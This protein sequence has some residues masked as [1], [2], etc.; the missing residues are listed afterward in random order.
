MS[1]S[2]R[3]FAV[4]LAT[5]VGL[6]LVLAATGHPRALAQPAASAAPSP[7][8]T[9]FDLEIRVPDL[10]AYVTNGGPKALASSGP[11]HNA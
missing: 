10:E 3:R 7:S 8:A 6:G 11:G 2:E 1:C 9:R 4:A 5:L